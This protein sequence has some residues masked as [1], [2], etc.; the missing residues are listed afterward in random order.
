[1][2]KGIDDLAP[3]VSR[4]GQGLGVQVT[5]VKA[6]HKRRKWHG[7]DATRLARGAAGRLP[8]ADRYFS[9]RNPSQHATEMR[10]TAQAEATT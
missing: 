4:G 6:Q 5:E 7:R 8:A 9:L 2:D 10:S 1:V 3:G